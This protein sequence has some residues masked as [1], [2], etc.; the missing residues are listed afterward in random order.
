[1]KQLLARVAG[2]VLVAAA[3]YA[4]RVMLP[5]RYPLIFKTAGVA[6][7]TR[8]DVNTVATAYGITGAVGGFDLGLLVLG[9]GR[10]AR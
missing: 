6:V 10:R 1:M 2:L 4:T 9:I 5:A 3:I 8:S 7:L